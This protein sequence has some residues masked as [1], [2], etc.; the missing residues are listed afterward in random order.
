VHPILVGEHEPQR[1]VCV[2]HIEPLH[3]ELVELLR[4]A[5]RLRECG[6]DDQDENKGCDACVN[7]EQANLASK[8]LSHDV[9]CLVRPF[10]RST[11]TVDETVQ[12]PSSKFKVQSSKFKVQSSKFKVSSSVLISLRS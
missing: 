11:S 5:S 2:D 3:S 8:R 4:L 6:G 9:S 7:L 10:A 12:V 1:A